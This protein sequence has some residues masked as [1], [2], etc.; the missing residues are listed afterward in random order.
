MLTRAFY[1]SRIKGKFGPLVL[2]TLQKKCVR[3]NREAGVTSFLFHDHEQIFQVLEGEDAQVQAALQRINASTTHKDMKIRAVM[4]SE[5][6]EFETWSFGAT[7]VDDPDYKRAA[8]AAHVQDFFN[9]DVLQADRVLS[10]VASR[11]RRAV[12]MDSQNAFFRNLSA[13]KTL[14]GMPKS[15]RLPKVEP[16]P[17]GKTA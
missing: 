3:R 8:N 9:L 13:R 15:V 10:I 5:K 14:Q 2:L 1:Q 12:K 16:A 6:R 11:K 17:M 7:N 4:R